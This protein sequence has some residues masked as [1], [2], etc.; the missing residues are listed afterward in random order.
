MP[1]RTLFLDFD[2]FFASV[3]QQERPELRGRAVG[4]A[5]LAVESTSLIAVSVEG[6]RHG[7]RR[8]MR[9][10]EARR[11]FPALVVVEARPELY[12]RYHHR[13]VELIDRFARVGEV[14]SIDEV[15]CDLPAGATTRAA[16]EA[17]ARRLKAAI[18]A[19]AGERL[20]CSI[21]LAPNALLAKIAAERSKPDGL[22]TLEEAELP[23]A[24]HALALR[25]VPGIGER[26]ERRLRARGIDSVAALCAAPRGLMRKLWGSV[27][28]ER[29][30]DRLRGGAV[31]APPRRTSSLGHAHV[32]P[33]ELRHEEGAQATAHR[34]LQK[35]AM[36]L[37]HA[38]YR[39]GGL[40]LG[41]KFWRRP[42]WSDA[43]T[44]LATEDTLELTRTLNALWARRPFE[45]CVGEW[46]G[47]SV[48]LFDL[49]PAAAS[50]QTLALVDTG[51][52][53]RALDAAVD[54]LNRQFG[55]NAVIFGG[56]LGATRYAPV[57]IAFG[58]IPDLVVEAGGPASEP[59][60]T[61]LLA[62]AAELARL[63]LARRG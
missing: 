58:R 33:P 42:R 24:L 1:L 14:G 47:V 12:V 5:P 32:L 4:V 22:A 46:R 10:A 54:S 44:F 11:R 3:E 18:R 30:H 39:A 31:P 57:R 23:H 55:R 56:A 25:D 38:G 16:A 41:L 7:L 17:L 29:M 8:G 45:A 53:R 40:H 20:T 51:Q 49:A 63:R 43:V 62:D 19:A 50:T 61:A 21:G 36:R 35:A 13:L 28:G 48:T 26:M 37:R 52:S 6:K 60:G 2:S 34:L 59:E 27:E 9:V 15:A